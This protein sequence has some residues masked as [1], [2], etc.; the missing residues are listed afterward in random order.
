MG[1]RIAH[2]LY[3]AIMEPGPDLLIDIH[4][5]WI[6]SIPYV[7]L[8]PRSGFRSNKVYNASHRY[9]L[10]TGLLVVEDADTFD[11]GSNTLAG[12]L[13]ADG[14]AS[15]TLEAGGAS[16]VSEGDVRIGVDAILRVLAAAGMIDQA[17]RP[18]YLDGMKHLPSSVTQYSN[19]PLCSASGLL[20]F[21]VRPADYVTK[22]K[23]VARI[24]NA[25]GTVE[26][27]L[28]AKSDGV[29]LGYNDHAVAMPG[30]EVIAVANI[31]STS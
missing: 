20:R 24:Y 26:E 8:D 21:V 31:R 9:A 13:A 10:A 27:V 30:K 6:R 16:A 18:A 29:V 4:N 11:A 1:E 17:D 7:V 19:E 28:K 22:G 25:F 2:R 3:A 14:I 23:T 15:L 12:A 5:D